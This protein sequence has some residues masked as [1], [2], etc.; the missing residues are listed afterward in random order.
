[1]VLDLR[2][3]VGV[4]L[5]ELVD[6]VVLTE[7]VDDVVLMEL[8]DDVVLRTVDVVVLCTVDLCAGAPQAV[9]AQV[10]TPMKR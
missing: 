7:L 8:V 10:Q 4:I 9:T 6:D 2:V 5:M 1:M 3:G